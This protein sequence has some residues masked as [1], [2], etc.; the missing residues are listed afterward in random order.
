MEIY[1]ENRAK[2][3]KAAM[4]MDLKRENK[5]IFDEKGVKYERGKKA[6]IQNLL[7][8]LAHEF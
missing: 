1:Y 5:K 7:T 8:H 2:Y 6:E 4:F 3:F